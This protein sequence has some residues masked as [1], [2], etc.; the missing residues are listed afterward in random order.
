MHRMWKQSPKQS[1]YDL[2]LHRKKNPLLKTTWSYRGPPPSPPANWIRHRSL[3]RYTVAAYEMIEW[4]CGP[5]WRRVVVITG[6]VS[7][8]R[9]ILSSPQRE[10]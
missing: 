2:R 7:C 1:V 4:S 6:L 8:K 5:V 3:V 9:M 10:P